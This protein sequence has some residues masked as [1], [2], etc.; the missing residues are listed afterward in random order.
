M[1]NQAAVQFVSQR[2]AE[3]LDLA[4]TCETMMEACLASS[5]D[6]AGLGCDNMTVIIVGLLNGKTRE[7]WTANVRKR[8]SASTASPVIPT[9]DGLNGGEGVN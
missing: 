6:F 9:D 8:F 4:Q 5:S 2:I 3:G 1:T 7:E